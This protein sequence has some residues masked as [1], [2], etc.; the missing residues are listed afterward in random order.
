[1]ILG[2]FVNGKRPNFSKNVKKQQVTQ[3]CSDTRATQSL[4]ER[5]LHLLQRVRLRGTL[6]FEK[7]NYSSNDFCTSNP[8]DVLFTIETEHLLFIVTNVCLLSML[9]EEKV[10]FRS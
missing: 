4:K 8:E 6:L 3:Y 10:L 9:R 2:D 1:M 7:P 5:K